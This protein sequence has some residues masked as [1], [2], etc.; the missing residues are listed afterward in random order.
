MPDELIKKLLKEGRLRG[1]K[2]AFPQAE[3]LLRQAIFDLA[4]A[5]KIALIAERATY[6]L[7]YM[8][9]LKAGRALLLSRG[10]MPHDGAQHRT[11][12]EL[13]SRIL[14]GKYRDLTEQF[15]T[16]RRKRNEMT[17]EAG[18]L[19]SLSESQK[20]FA[21]AISLVQQILTAVKADNPQLELDFNLSEEKG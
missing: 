16:M 15:E 19:L 13:T 21:D 14:G 18:G 6:L 1:Q 7:A 11:V 17:Y 12:V 5:R 20:A 10:Y 2:G 4:E 8:A 9:M 3:A